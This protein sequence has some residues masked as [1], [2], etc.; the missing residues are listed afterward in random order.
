MPGRT[1]KVHSRTTLS[2]NRL[3]VIPKHSHVS[4]RR[5]DRD[6]SQPL[7]QSPRKLLAA[8]LRDRFGTSVTSVGSSRI[9]RSRAGGSPSAARFISPPSSRAI[10]MRRRF[11]FT[12]RG[13]VSVMSVDPAH[14]SRYLMSSQ[15]MRGMIL[16]LHGHPLH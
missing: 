3:L 13:S 12:E 9:R 6:L 2:M 7:Q 10:S 5:S 8:F 4:V 16:G 1:S 15:G 14:S 11:D